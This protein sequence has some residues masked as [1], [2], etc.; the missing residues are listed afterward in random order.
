MHDAK[1]QK[2][3]DF[4][5]FLSKFPHTQKLNPKPLNPKTY[6]YTLNL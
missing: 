3:L 5:A 6:T 2:E 4:H 1:F